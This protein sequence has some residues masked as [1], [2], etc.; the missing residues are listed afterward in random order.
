MTGGVPGLRGT[1]HISFSVPDLDQAIAFFCEV[2]GC[3]YF[4]P[5]GPFRDPEGTWFSDN[6]QLHPR[7]EV[8][9]ACLLRCGNGSNFEIF[10]F[11]APDQRREM[12]QMSDWG[13]MHL[14]FYVDDMDAAITYLAGQGVEV[15]GG[16][17]PGTG[18][19]CGDEATFGHFYSPWGMLLEFVSFPNGKAYMEGRDR[20]LW[21]PH[22]SGALAR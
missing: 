16:K 11:K 20:V 8:T 10:E 15:L 5:L 18:P 13:G 21:R 12:P 17:K 19:E 4:Y 6:F 2:L 3:E 9:R 14:A 1:E 22:V 7:T